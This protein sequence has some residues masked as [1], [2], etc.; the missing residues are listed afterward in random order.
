MSVST[1]TSGKGR[2]VLT[3]LWFHTSISGLSIL[4][5][6]CDKV[7]PECGISRVSKEEERKVN[8]KLLL[9]EL[10][11]SD[12][13]CSPVSLQRV[14]CWLWAECRAQTEVEDIPPAVQILLLRWEFP[15]AAWPWAT[16]ILE[17]SSGRM[18]SPWSFGETAGV[19]LADP[20]GCL[21]FAHWNTGKV[22]WLLVLQKVIT[23]PDLGGRKQNLHFNVHMLSS[24]SNSPPREIIMPLARIIHAGQVC[25]PGLRAWEM[26]VCV[27]AV[28]PGW[29]HCKDEPGAWG[30]VIPNKVIGEP[31][32]WIHAVF[33]SDTVSF[34]GF[35]GPVTDLSLTVLLLLPCESRDVQCFEGECLCFSCLCT[36]SVILVTGIL[37]KEIWSACAHWGSRGLVSMSADFFLEKQI[38][39]MHKDLDC[40]K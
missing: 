37:S 29:K 33:I 39:S 30:K 22:L 18:F 13:F 32:S 16:Y 3:Y 2:F 27:N 31:F 17:V 10:I 40:V 9:L 35:F 7:W 36:G 38:L 4:L 23:G 11:T 26:P 34:V 15:G 12:D 6:C 25:L 8:N 5:S 19:C 14:Q 1:Y 28:A 24:F 21:A 20:K